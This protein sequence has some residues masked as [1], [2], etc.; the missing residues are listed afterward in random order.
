MMSGSLPVPASHFD[1]LRAVSYHRGSHTALD[2]AA[3]AALAQTL[4]DDLAQRLS[5]A[6][7]Q[8]DTATQG[9]AAAAASTSSDPRDAALRHGR[10]LVKDALRTTRDVIAGLLDAATPAAPESPCAFPVQCA[11]IVEAAR[12]QSRQGIH[13]DVDAAPLPADPPAAVARVLLRAIRELLANAGKHASG[14]RVALALR[15]VDGAI[16]ITIADD[17]PGFDAALLHQPARGHCGLRGLPG[18]LR[19]VG[20][21]LALETAPGRGVRARVRW[22]GAGAP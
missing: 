1:D 22:P 20:A 21:E 8:I 17:G 10:Q 3:R 9:A 16:D 12:Q 19:Q 5:F 13:I 15:G 4:H 2:P 14:A 18:A 6:L 11:R 7:I